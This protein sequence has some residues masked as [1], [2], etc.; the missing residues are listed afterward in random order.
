[1]KLI[2]R[3]GWALR[4]KNWHPTTNYIGVYL[5]ERFKA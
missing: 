2:A 4:M 3:L 5:Y 1:M